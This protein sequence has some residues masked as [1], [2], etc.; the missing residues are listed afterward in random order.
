MQTKTQVPLSRVDTLAVR[1]TASFWLLAAIAYA[2]LSIQKFSPFA[3]CFGIGFASIALGVF[4]MVPWML[5]AAAW[6]FLFSDL[7]ILCGPLNPFFAIDMQFRWDDH[8]LFLYVSGWLA[9]GGTL[10]WLATRTDRV[11]LTLLEHRSHAQ[12]GS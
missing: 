3:L 2:Y 11:R 7:L 8:W 10:F 9:F 5:R 1:A 4:R 6:L 12:H